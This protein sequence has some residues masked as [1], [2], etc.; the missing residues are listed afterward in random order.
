MAIPN[1]DG[2]ATGTCARFS[3][4][5]V[6]AQGVTACGA[7]FLDLD[8][9]Q[10]GVDL[11]TAGL[12]D[13]PYLVGETGG[14][15]SIPDSCGDLLSQG[16]AGCDENGD[17]LF[18]DTVVDLPAPL[19]FPCRDIN[20][21]GFVNI[22]TGATWGNQA[23]GVHDASGDVLCDSATE[24][25]PSTKSKCRSEDIESTIPMP[26]LSC[27]AS[28]TP[29]DVAPGGTTTCTV[30]YNNTAACI[31]DVGTVERFRCGTASFLRFKTDYDQ[32]N[33]SV[34]MISTSGTRR[35]RHHPGRRRPDH[36]DAVQPRGHG[37]DRRRR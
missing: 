35:R 13:G 3:I 11:N 15:N 28:C 16:N 21:D 22:P 24:L 7:G 31:P 33:G 20:A 4:D 1:S 10:S 19:T 25:V 17:G 23:N 27:T 29:A 26:S 30:T 12:A 14:S 32:A 36:L 34:S 37:R 18:D 6:G 5:P 8:G 2:V 9:P